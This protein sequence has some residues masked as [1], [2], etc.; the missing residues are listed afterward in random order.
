[1]MLMIWQILGRLA[2][3]PIVSHKLDPLDSVQA[4]DRRCLTVLSLIEASVAAA[5]TNATPVFR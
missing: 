2:L 4:T 3:S 5:P 1:M